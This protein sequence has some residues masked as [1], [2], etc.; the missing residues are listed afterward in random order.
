MSNRDSSSTSAQGLTYDR[1]WYQAAFLK[2]FQGWYRILE[3]TSDSFAVWQPKGG[4]V[5]QNFVSESGL[6]C[7]GVPRMMPA[8][9][10][11][12]ACAENGPTIPLGNGREVDPREILYKAFVHGTD[13]KHRDFWRYVPTKNQRQVESSIVAWSLWL[14][15]KWLLPRLT[16]PQIQNIQAWLASCTVA[17]DHFNNWSL[18]TA[19]NHAARY[20]LREHGFEGSLEEIRRDLIPGDELYIGDGWM[21]DKKFSNIDYYNFWVFGS[22]HCYLRAMLPDYDH[23]MLDRALR[24]LSRR[25]PD[26]GYLIGRDGMNVQFGRSLPYR[27]GWLSG[28][29]A[30]HYIDLP[31]VDPGLSRMMLARNIEAWLARGSIDAEGALREKLTA[32]GSAGGTSTYINCGHPYWGMQALLCLALPDSHPFWSSRVTQL[33]VE[34]GDFQI[35]RQGPGFVF[36]GFRQSGEVRLYSLRNCHPESSALYDKFVYSSAFPCNSGTA[37]HKTAWDN[38]FALRMPDGT[39]VG[40]KEILEVDT[41]D[42]I[43]VRTIR[44]FS[45]EGGKVE[46]TVET[47]LTIEGSGYSSRHE[48]E[49][50]ECGVEGGQWIEGGFP[51]GFEDEEQAVSGGDETKRWA[52]IAEKR[53]VAS[54]KLEGW[55]TLHAPEEWKELWPKYEEEANIL[56][57]RSIHCLLTAPVQ[58]GKTVLRSRHTARLGG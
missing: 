15:R 14:S 54:E 13:P 32:N 43:V 56:F 44:R 2:I 12:A 37:K 5:L 47:E 21:F 45:L 31:A 49:V 48:V 9:A 26:L 52:R 57:A 55:K 42:G 39:S 38:Q 25:L 30:A 29:I 3:Q 51:L 27:W 40:P 22:H 33:P 18:F 50:T 23:P 17:T 11:W 58:A 20:A 7:D 28:L 24:Q 6:Q 53:E 19:T 35:P 1:S 8:L 10:A 34:E 46:A 4:V 41:N 36:Q 16:G